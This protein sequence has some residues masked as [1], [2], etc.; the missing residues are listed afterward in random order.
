MIVV[1]GHSVVFLLLCIVLGAAL[2]FAIGA[3]TQTMLIAKDSP[4]DVYF[5]FLV[6]IIL[7]GSFVLSVSIALKLF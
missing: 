2:G 4:Y 6:R 5:L 7:L 1:Y 3:V